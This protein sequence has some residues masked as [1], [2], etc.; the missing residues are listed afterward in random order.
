[1][2]CTTNQSTTFRY[3]LSLLVHGHQGP[4]LYSGVF[5]TEEVDGVEDKGSGDTTMVD[6]Q[7]VLKAF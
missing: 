2:G 1:M 6:V 7:T 3:L 5:T 4:H